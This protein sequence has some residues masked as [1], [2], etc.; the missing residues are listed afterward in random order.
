MADAYLMHHGILGQKWGVRRYQNEDGS[1][2]TAGRKR[3][4]ANEYRLKRNDPINKAAMNI[5][6]QTAKG[7]KV[8]ST[9][10]FVKQTAVSAALI[11][12]GVV[13]TRAVLKSDAGKAMA[14]TKMTDLVRQKASGKTTLNVRATMKYGKAATKVAIAAIG[15]GALITAGVARESGAI[16]GYSNYLTSGRAGAKLNK[17]NAAA[18]RK[19]ARQSQRRIVY[20]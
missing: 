12:A 3:L 11:T 19:S 14:A 5:Q 15:S 1:Y 6:K 8:S 10:S 4:H 13:A 16:L 2:T 18:I 7:T 17:Q 20:S 9:Q